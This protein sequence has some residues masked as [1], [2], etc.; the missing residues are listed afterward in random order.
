MTALGSRRLRTGACGTGAR[1]F[2][3]PKGLSDQ[4]GTSD[5]PRAGQSLEALGLETAPCAEGPAGPGSAL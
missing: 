5:L 4:L 3:M 1:S 2:S